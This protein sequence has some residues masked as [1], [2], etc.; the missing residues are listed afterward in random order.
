MDNQI[1]KILIKK[2]LKKSIRFIIN[3][4]TKVLNS[5]YL[6]LKNNENEHP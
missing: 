6:L 5:I 3:K 2:K 4:K 1:I